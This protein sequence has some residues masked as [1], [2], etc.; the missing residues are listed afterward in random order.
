MMKSLLIAG[1]VTAA[2]LP[3]ILICSRPPWDDSSY[4]MQQ[5]GYWNPAIEGWV[6]GPVYVGVNGGFETVAA[7]DVAPAGFNAG[8]NIDGWVGWNLYGGQA[9][10][11]DD[12]VEG[13][14]YFGGSSAAKVWAGNPGDYSG[15]AVDIDVSKAQCW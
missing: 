9:W 10:Q 2:K 1:A 8:D 6:G 13:S 4:L 3:M 5:A 12:T 15:A 14:G 11:A 7:G